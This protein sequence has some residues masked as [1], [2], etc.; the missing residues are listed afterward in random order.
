MVKVSC[1]ALGTLTFLEGLGA[2]YKTRVHLDAS[3]ANGIIERTG[4]D[5]IRH[6]D[7]NVLWLQEQETRGKVPI[8]KVRWNQEPC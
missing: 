3:A 4:L 8:E 1:E 6:I 7:V 5:R 2:D